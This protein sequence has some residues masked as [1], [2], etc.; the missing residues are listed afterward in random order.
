MQVNVRFLW[1]ILAVVAMTG[2]FAG[3]ASAQDGPPGIETRRIEPFILDSVEIVRHDVFDSVATIPI[4]TPILD[5][6]HI[7][8]KESVVRNEIFVEQG[9]TVTQ[10][11]LDEIERNMRALSIFSVIDFQ[12]IPDSSD[13][14]DGEYRHASLRVIT[15][16]SWSTRLSATFE[17]DDDHNAYGVSV[18]ETNLFGYAQQVGVGVDYTSINDRGWRYTGSYVDPNIAGS[19]LRLSSAVGVSDAEH[20]VAASLGL[21]YYTDRLPSAFNAMVGYFDGT[22]FFHFHTLPTDDPLAI[23]A[24]K[25]DLAGWY[26]ISKISRDVFRTSFNVTF[27]RTQRDDPTSPRM[28]FENSVGAFFGISSLGRTFTRVRDADFHGESEVPVGGMGSVTLGKISPIYGGLDNAVYVGGEARKA[29]ISDGD[30]YGF[31]MVQAGTAVAGR[32]AQFTL[33]HATLSGAYDIDPGWIVARLDQVNVWNWQ[34][35]LFQPLDNGNG[36][37]GYPRNLL[38]GDNR[39]V[40]NAEYRL[41]PVMK[42]LMFQIGAAAFYDVGSVW[43]QGEHLGDLKFHSSAGI[44]IRIANRRGEFDKGLLRVDLAYNFDT[45]R[46]AQVIISSQEAFDIF[47][48]LDYRPPAPYVP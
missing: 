7:L 40:L 11:T 21:P 35:Y 44:G 30:L 19:H 47:G 10:Q 43:N 6:I 1:S 39:M 14:D 15:R 20:S 9:D 3:R 36:L 38:Y 46:I 33:E 4:I 28:A 17:H 42:I 22:D 18:R 12:V 31:A 16:D 48:T 26:S 13:E 32:S 25:T 5:Y 24:I 2:A 23:H 41:N 27:N 34:R 8:T 45:R 29:M 37:R